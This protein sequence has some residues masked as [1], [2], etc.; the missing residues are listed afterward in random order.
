MGRETNQQKA[1]QLAHAAVIHDDVTTADGEFDIF[2]GIGA[3]DIQRVANTY[4]TPQQPAGDHHPAAR[5]DPVGRGR[6]RARRARRRMTRMMHIDHGGVPGRASAALILALF[7]V[8]VCPWVAVAQVKDWPVEGPPRPLPARDVNFPPYEI[9]TI[10]E[11]HARGRG[12]APRAAR[13]DA[14]A[15]AAGRQRLRC[16]GKERRRGACGGAPRPGDDHAFGRADRRHD[17][18]DRRRARHGRGQRLEL[19]QRRRDEGQ[20]GA[21][22]RSAVRRR[23]KSGVQTGRDRSPAPAGGL[24]PQGQLRG[25]R[26]RGERRVR[27]ARLR[28]PSVRDAGLRHARITAVDHSGGPPRLSSAVLRTEQRHSRRRRRCHRRRGVR[29]RRAG[30]RQLGQARRPP[31]AI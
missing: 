11:W 28:V 17:R 15:A 5:P 23:A 10:A 6:L 8:L 27:S 29:G 19:R 9:R 30:L 24:G 16:T 25:P 13:G 12:D 21:R 1:L 14:A 4:F 7:A 2:M 31:R 22:V 18:F 3:K 20:P 26:F